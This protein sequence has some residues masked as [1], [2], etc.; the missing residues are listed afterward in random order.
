MLSHLRRVS[1]VVRAGAVFEHPALAAPAPRSPVI[2]GADTRWTTAATALALL[3]TPAL[4]FLYAWHGAR[5][6]NAVSTLYQNVIAIGV[7]GLLW[8]AIG[9]SLIF[10]AGNDFIGDI[11]KPCWKGV[12]QY[13]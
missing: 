12:G 13:A 3:L 2:N 5:Q 11:P 1:W 10:T 8:A 7:I 9:V 4:G 6:K